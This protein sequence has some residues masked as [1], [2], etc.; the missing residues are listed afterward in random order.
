MLSNNTSD[1]RGL[2]IRN[3]FFVLNQKHTLLF[4][5]VNACGSVWSVEDTSGLPG[6]A[7]FKSDALASCLDP[8]VI[9]SL[10]LSFPGG[11]IGAS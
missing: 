10:R 1:H 11:S 8:A 3:V 9:V 2:T 5:T 4:I 7:G 6:A